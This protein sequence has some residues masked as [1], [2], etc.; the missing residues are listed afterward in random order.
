VKRLREVVDALPPER[1]HKIATRQQTLLIEFA[2]DAD[3]ARSV[4]NRLYGAEINQE[5]DAI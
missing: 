3:L 5:G 1:Q 4:P 2:R